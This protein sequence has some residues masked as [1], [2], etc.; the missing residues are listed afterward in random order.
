[1]RGLNKAFCVSG[2]LVSAEGHPQQAKVVRAGKDG[3]T[4]D[5]AAIAHYQIAAGRTTSQPER[6]HL[7][8]QA[9]RLSESTVKPASD[10]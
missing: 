9:A 6:N 5:L 2:E 4:D 1:M 10:T 7:I 8:T 3:A